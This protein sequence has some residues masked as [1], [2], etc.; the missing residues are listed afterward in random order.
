MMIFRLLL[1]NNLIKNLFLVLSVLVLVHFLVIFIQFL[2]FL[3]VVFVI[4]VVI[5]IGNDV[6]VNLLCDFGLCLMV[7]DR[8]V[9]FHTL[10]QVVLTRLL[11]LQ[12]V[13]IRDIVQ[14]RYPPLDIHTLRIILLRL[15]PRIKDP[16]LPGISPHPCH[17][18]PIA[19][20][21]RRRIIYK[22]LGKEL[23]ALLPVNEQVLD[24]ET[25]DVLSG[26]VVHVPGGV[27]LSHAGVDEGD[28][29]CSLL[30]S[31]KVLLVLV[32]FYV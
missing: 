32:P 1:V 13:L 24:Q 6:P 3:L 20:I 25:C 2:S 11:P 10:L 19:R 31:L 7:Y 21:L 22:H 5:E 26:S 28:A 12:N 30:P 27:H 15:Q 8:F 4:V 16:D 18:L 17:I 9:I 14:L 23:L 29:C